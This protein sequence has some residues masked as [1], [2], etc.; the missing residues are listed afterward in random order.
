MRKGIPTIILILAV[1]KVALPFLLQH[2]AY[3]LHRDEYLYYAQGQHL[4]FGFLE[5]PPLIGLL[6]AV[7]SLLGGT[8]FWIK[9]WP[10]LFGAATLLLTTRIAKEFGGGLFAQTVAALGILF[11]GYLRIHFLFQPNFLDIFFWTLSAYYIIRYTNTQAPRYLYLLAISLALGWWSK[12]S[13]LFF[14]ASFFIALLLSPQRKMLQQKH[15]WFAAVLGLVLILPN[16]IWQHLHN[17]PLAHHMA[18]LRDTQL[19]YINRSDFLKEQLL[20]LLPVAFVWVGGLAWLLR[21]SAFRIIAFIYLGIIVLLMLGSGKGYY[22]LGAYPMLLAAGGVWLEGMSVSKRWVR[23][24][25]VALILLLALPSI[26]ILLPMQ[27]PQQMAET[28][29][30]WG[31]EKVGLLK[32]EDQQSHPLQQDFA[33]MLG[34]KEMAAKTERIYNALPPASKAGT[35]VFCGSYGQAGALS[36]Y[37]QTAAF[38]NSVVSANGTFLLWMP[39]PLLFENIIFVD[40]DAPEHPLFQHFQKSMLVDS[41]TNPLSRQYRNKIYI[42]QHAGALAGPMA[43]TALDSLRTAFTR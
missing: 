16:I 1:L 12:Y 15:F 20:M 38:R 42:F 26:P 4:D 7:S 14:V 40:D 28:N 18:E 22:A 24:A 34:W 3:E 32:W 17:W 35:I 43:N 5:N 6:G 31:L 41:V 37:G 23:Y 33:D 39:R 11:S 27:A 25:A 29:R 8:P 13:V 10:A 19:Q 30:R 9:F 2:P 21:K 36:Y